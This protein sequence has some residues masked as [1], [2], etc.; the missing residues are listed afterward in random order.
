MLDPD[1]NIESEQ[2][3]LKTARCYTSILARLCDIFAYALA[4]GVPW[5]IGAWWLCEAVVFY[6]GAE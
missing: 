1:V 4:V 3:E 5:V 2:L 6:L